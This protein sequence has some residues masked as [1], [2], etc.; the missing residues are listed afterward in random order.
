MSQHISPQNV[1]A[2][3]ALN[4]NVKNMSGS[5][6]LLK[7]CQQMSG[8]SCL[9][10]NMSIKCLGGWGVA[11]RPGGVP[12]LEGQAWQG[13][14][15]AAPRQ[16]EPGGPVLARPRLRSGFLAWRAGPWAH[17]RGS[18]VSGLG[19]ARRTGRRWFGL[20]WAGR[21]NQASSLGW[22]SGLGWA[23]AGAELGRLGCVR[24]PLVSELSWVGVGSV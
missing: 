22:S 15:C 13:P 3:L 11:G 8:P 16:A 1:W 19:R 14:A 7:E 4:E 6:H 20:P 10:T 9:S 17:A 21:A 12:H 24:V 2:E 18:G 23:W 5:S